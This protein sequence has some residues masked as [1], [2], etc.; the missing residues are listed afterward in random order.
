MTCSK[1]GKQFYGRICP[2]CD[3]P[4]SA[5]DVGQEQRDAPNPAPT[6][7]GKYKISATCKWSSPQ[8]FYASDTGEK[9]AVAKLLLD[10]KY[11]VEIEELGEPDEEDITHGK[12][13]IGNPPVE[14]PKALYVTCRCQHCDGHIEF[15]ANKF[16]EESS[17]VPCPHCGAETKLSLPEQNA[18]P[19]LSSQPS[20][21]ASQTD[22]YSGEGI[23]WALR[24]VKYG[25]VGS[26]ALLGG[27]YLYG[28]DVPK[29]YTEA[30]KWLRQAAEQGDPTAEKSLGFCYYQ[31]YGVAQ[32][33]TEAEKWI[34]KAAEQGDSVGQYQLGSLYQL[35]QGLPQNTFE[36]F[37]W[38]LKAAEQGHVIAQN[39]V[40][41]LYEEGK[42][43]DQ[44]YV[45]AHKWMSLAAAQGYKG[46]DEDS[47]AMAL[48]MSAAQRE[49]SQRRIEKFKLENT[50]QEQSRDDGIIG[51]LAKM[52]DPDAQEIMR[53]VK[54]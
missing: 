10:L 31:G 52:G 15:D 44:D 6:P 38:W 26:M 9:D 11:K 24:G 17:I 40:G 54:S 18:P 51:R 30:V 47:N 8:I 13:P 19:I 4:V 2:G 29:N 50:K 46:A 42:I 14:Q 28:L 20:R 36:A 16:S 41:F 22:D 7:K 49:E 39:N 43:I 1:C 34:R 37:T 45:E 23:K 5:I 3:C 21:R 27:A 25:D 48:K 53:R 33:Y 35:G 12:K 32:N